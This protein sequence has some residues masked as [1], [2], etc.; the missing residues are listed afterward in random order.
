M[1]VFPPLVGNC[2]PAVYR[3]QP[4]GGVDAYENHLPQPHHLFFAVD[5]LRGVYRRT[6]LAGVYQ[7]VRAAF[8]RNRRFGIRGR[9]VA[10]YL[11]NNQLLQLRC[12]GKR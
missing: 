7:G 12:G 8:F 4:A 3:Y 10:V 9:G 2:R 5:N 1:G 6:Q 11:V